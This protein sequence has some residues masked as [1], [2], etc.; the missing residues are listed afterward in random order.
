[1]MNALSVRGA[2]SWDRCHRHQNDIAE[3]ATSRGR[4]LLKLEMPS[5]LGLRKG[6]FGRERNHEVLITVAK[7]M[8]VLI[9][10]QSL[11]F[12]LFLRARLFGPLRPC[13]LQGFRSR[14]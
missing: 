12:S 3:A 6:P 10:S 11:L 8:F 13:L 14:I 5:V 7:E 2:L 1:M 4:V 9:S